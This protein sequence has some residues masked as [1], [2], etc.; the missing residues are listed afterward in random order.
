MTAFAFYAEPTF[1]AESEN[2]A[3]YIGAG[4]CGNL[5]EAVVIGISEECR[6]SVIELS[7]DEAA[8]LR[9]LLNECI[10]DGAA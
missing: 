2:R 4:M 9:N 6:T 5:D 8:H 7:L 10:D 3:L 1:I